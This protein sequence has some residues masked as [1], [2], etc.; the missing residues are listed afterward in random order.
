MWLGAS[1]QSPCWIMW[2]SY[3]E[4]GFGWRQH[5]HF[6]F[7]YGRNTKR[8]IVQ[9]NSWNKQKDLYEIVFAKSFGRIRQAAAGRADT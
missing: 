6:F 4:F 9:L 7:Q 8:G 3:I 1:K 5:F 2:S